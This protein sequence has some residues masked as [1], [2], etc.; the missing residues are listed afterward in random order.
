MAVVT[1]PDGHGSMAVLEED[2]Q[3]FADA[4]AYLSAQ[5]NDV[6]ADAGIAGIA[7]SAQ[8]VYGS[9]KFSTKG[10]HGWSYAA[11]CLLD[12]LEGSQFEVQLDGGGVRL[13][14]PADRSRHSYAQLCDL[15]AD[16]SPG[17]VRAFRDMNGAPPTVQMRRTPMAQ[18]LKGGVATGVACLATPTR[19]SPFRRHDPMRT[20]LVDGGGA[21]RACLGGVQQ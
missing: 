21:G 6:L 13:L 20:L 8:L 19:A 12:T 1:R 10:V 3:S 9:A 11:K 5:V 18:H 15:L 2:S 7:E 17:Y 4:A 14:S 16:L